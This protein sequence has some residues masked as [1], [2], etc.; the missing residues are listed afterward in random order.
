M[1]SELLKRLFRAIN[2]GSD[3]N[4]DKICKTIVEDAKRK[5]HNKLAEQLEEILKKKSGGESENSRQG[6]LTNLPK[7]HTDIKG[8]L[9]TIDQ[10]ESLHSPM[11]LPSFVEKRFA[12]IEKEYAARGRLG[13]YGLKP[14]KKVLFYGPPGCG[15]TLGA[16]RVAYNTG[17]PLIKVKFD[18]MLSSYFGESASNLRSIFEECEQ[19]PSV[20]LLDECDF[21]ARA[22]KGS[23]DVGEVPRIVN[24]LLQLLED[25]DLPG[26]VIAT[27]NIQEELDPALFRRFDEAFEV[28]LPGHEEIYKLLKVT[29]SSIPSVKNMPWS[30]LAK[31]LDGRSA[32]DVVKC[33]QNAAK[34]AV[35][36]NSGRV[37][38]KHL[39]S[40][41]TEQYLG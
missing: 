35:L 20:L 16:R 41:I 24:T 33:A 39:R 19:S 11:V 34:L 21:I 6:H 7:K 23:K 27:T 25:Y 13:K 37:T 32:A 40:S 9:V 1:N 5:K 8:N 36:E 38:E 3:S 17:L 28:P 31:L 18:T 15:K 30:E 10:G 29:L 14:I 26:L 2:D 22:R 12:K 4:I